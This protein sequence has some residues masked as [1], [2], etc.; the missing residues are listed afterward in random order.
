MI[1]VVMGTLP[2]RKLVLSVGYES[3]SANSG[4]PSFSLEPNSHVEW[5]QT[6]VLII[7]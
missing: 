1:I 4:F 7:T 2:F 5:T 3:E 6:N